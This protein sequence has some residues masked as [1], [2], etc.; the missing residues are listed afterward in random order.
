M[1]ALQHCCCCTPLIS[2]C[3]LMQSGG[4][5][6]RVNAAIGKTCQLRSYL[7]VYHGHAVPPSKQAQSRSFVR[8][9]AC[10]DPWKHMPH[11]SSAR[12]RIRC[13]TSINMDSIDFFFFFFSEPWRK[14]AKDICQ[15]LLHN[16]NVFKKF[17]C[18]ILGWPIMS[19]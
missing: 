14:P 5:V 6:T 18:M 4:S 12:T 1:F 8:N 3:V 7:Y 2:F 10:R 11:Y 13:K 17:N 16:R 15:L 19:D 9:Q